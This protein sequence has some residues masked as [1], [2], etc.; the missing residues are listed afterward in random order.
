MDNKNNLS[1]FTNKDPNT[2]RVRL[3]GSLLAKYGIA[4]GIATTAFSILGAKTGWLDKELAAKIGLSGLGV[5]CISSIP[6]L[7]KEVDETKVANT[8]LNTTKSTFALGGN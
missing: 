7:A 6:F 1:A 8:I 5:T 4:A 2:G 3:N